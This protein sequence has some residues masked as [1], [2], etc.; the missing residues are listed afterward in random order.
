MSIFDHNVFAASAYKA[1]LKKS[2]RKFAENLEYF[3]A[4]NQRYRLWYVRLAEYIDLHADLSHSSVLEIGCNTGLLLF[5]V[6]KMGAS[7]C[8]GVDWTDY[9]SEFCWLNNVLNTNVAFYQ[10]QYDNLAHRFDTK[11]SI[12]DVV[13]NTVFLNHQSDPLHCLATLADHARKGLMLCVL[14]HES[15]R[16]DL[17]FGTVE[18]LHDLGA[19]RRFPLSLHN[20]VSISKPLLLWSLRELGFN[21]VEFFPQPECGPNAPPKAIQPFLVVYATRT[22]ESRSALFQQSRREKYNKEMAEA[23]TPQETIVRWLD[24]S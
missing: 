17:R 9:A 3:R 13:V 21:K 15:L 12:A 7:E 22:N 6:A 4:C 11:I 18:G 24:I 5:Y 8:I 20:D 16:M 1:L 14:S 19:R 2:G 23:A 10:S